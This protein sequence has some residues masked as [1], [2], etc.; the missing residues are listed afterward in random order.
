MDAVTLELET[1]RLEL[2]EVQEQ[3]AK[4]QDRELKLQYLANLAEL[5]KKE[6][7]LLEQRA[8]VWRCCVIW[9]L[10]TPVNTCRLMQSTLWVHVLALHGAGAIEHAQLQ[11]R[12]TALHSVV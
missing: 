8:G 6:N 12:G 4:E 7:L 1:T 3:A 10:H 2:K 9:Q 11:E 5:R